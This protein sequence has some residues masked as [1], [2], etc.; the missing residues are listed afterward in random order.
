MDA[1]TLKKIKSKIRSQ[2]TLTEFCEQNGLRIATVSD[3]LNNKTDIKFSTLK[4]ITDATG[5]TIIIQ[6]KVN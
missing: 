5:F 2:S 3:F 1:E 6:S 4:K